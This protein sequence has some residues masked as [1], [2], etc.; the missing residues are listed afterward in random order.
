MTE[1]AFQ[2]VFDRLNELI[3][4]LEINPGKTVQAAQLV[5]DWLASGADADLDILPAINKAWVK[6]PT[7]EKLTSARY[8]DKAVRQAHA[9][10][11]GSAE[12]KEKQERLKATRIALKR[13]HGIYIPTYEEATLQQYEKAHGTIT[14]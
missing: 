1:S 12:E 7:G 14:L 8:F 10:R 5:N 6:V 9:T 2:R 13:K 4:A 3:P 11:I